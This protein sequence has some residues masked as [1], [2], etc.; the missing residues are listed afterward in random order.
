MDIKLNK[1]TNTGKRL[2]DSPIPSKVT[3][4]Q[5]P[6]NIQIVREPDR[7]ADT[8]STRLHRDRACVLGQPAVQDHL[9]AG[10]CGVAEA[11]VRRPGLQVQR[12]LLPVPRGVRHLQP[13]D[14][15]LGKIWRCSAF[16]V[17]VVNEGSESQFKLQSDDQTGR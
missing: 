10:L 14:H 11:P 9:P 13:R 12:H 6:Q 2:T 1:T 4:R 8:L 5:R 7:P 17:V 3:A 16:K 15:Q